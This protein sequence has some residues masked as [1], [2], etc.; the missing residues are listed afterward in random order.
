MPFVIIRTHAHHGRFLAPQTWSFAGGAR[1]HAFQT[2]VCTCGYFQRSTRAQ[3][4]SLALHNG[5]RLIEQ[6]HTQ[7]IGLKFELP[8]HSTFSLNGRRFNLAQQNVIY[9]EKS[10]SLS[11]K[12]VLL[13]F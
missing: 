9:A 5:D 4:D 7:K 6:L 10:E 12:R 13:Q 3:Y 11:I 1:A 8:L 2:K